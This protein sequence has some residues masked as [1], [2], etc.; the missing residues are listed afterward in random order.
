MLKPG[1]PAAIRYSLVERIARRRGAE[2]L[3]ISASEA[4]H[5]CF[6]EKGLAG[7]KKI[8]GIDPSGR[9]LVSGVEC[10][11]AFDFVPEEIEPQAM[12]EARGEKIDKAAAHRKF[13]RIGD[14]VGADI[15]IVVKEAEKP[16]TVHALA[17][18][19]PGRQLADAK[20]RQG[21]LRDSIY[22]G[23]QQSR[24][25]RCGLQRREAGQTFGHD[26]QR[27]RSAIIGKAIPG[28]KGNGLKFRCEP[29]RSLRDTAHRRLVCSYKDGGSPDRPRDI[30]KEWRKKS[31]RNARKRKRR[32]CAD[33][34]LEPIH[35][36]AAN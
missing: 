10:A 11:H 29:R 8:E 12:I 18:L 31:S 33:D 20:G 13:A 34:R 36:S 23:Q 21:P 26:A 3:P 25:G 19:K 14:C 32:R 24:L 16:L 6:V 4:L 9:P 17:S 1:H 30:G 28:G 15:A 35:F 22:G 27:G 5:A 7:G 2:K